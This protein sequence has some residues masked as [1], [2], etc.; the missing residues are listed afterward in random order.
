MLVVETLVRVPTHM[1]SR[2][3]LESQ[4]G[5]GPRSGEENPQRLLR[6][7]NYKRVESLRR[8]AQLCCRDET[9]I[10]TGNTYSSG[11]APAPCN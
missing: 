5:L 9:T 10:Q 2:G 4:V 6:C 11:L 7:T 8:S 3:V 1:E